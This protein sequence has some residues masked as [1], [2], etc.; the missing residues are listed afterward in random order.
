MKPDGSMKEDVKLPESEL[1]TKMQ[2]AFEAGEKA[3]NVI[4]LAAMG[5]EAAV[6][7]KLVND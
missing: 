3:V 6:D 4:I 2:D 7:F 5:E 1:G